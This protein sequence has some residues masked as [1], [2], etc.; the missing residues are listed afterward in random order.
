MSAAN[1]ITTKVPDVTVHPTN[2]TQVTTTTSGNFIDNIINKIPLPKWALIAI[3]A[4]VGL[5]IL[6]CVICICVK[7]CCK[8]KKKKKKKE[9]LNLESLNG[10]ITTNLVQPDLEDLD[11]T[12]ENYGKLQYSLYY[13]ATNETLTV[14]VIQAADLKAMDFGGTS[15]PYVTVYLVPEATQKFETKVFRKTLNPLFKEQF[16]FKTSQAEISDKTVVMK[17]YDFNR[18]SKHDIIGEVRIPLQTVNLNHALEEWHELTKAL[19]D[20]EEHLGDICFSLRYVPASNKLHVIILEAKNL[21][22]MDKG[23]SSDPY[24]KIRLILNNK[25]L[26]KKSTTVKKNTLNPYFNEPFMFDVNFE[27]IQKVK[28]VISIW[29]HDKMSKNDA[30]GRLFLGCGATG[31]QLR[32]WSDMLANPR[33]PIAQWHVLQSKAEVDKALKELKANSHKKGKGR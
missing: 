9:Q 6:I 27:E 3:C 28:L 16:T 10:S 24:V 22:T 11:G 2:T 30:I 23:G 5:V 19:K 4:G 21:K 20:E 29:D 33:R 31:N 1:N 14:G 15:D 18:F 7:C 13:D 25:K 8:K 12:I 32:H 17:V 26:K